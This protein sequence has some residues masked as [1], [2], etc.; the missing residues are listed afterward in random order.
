MKINH[1]F[2]AVIFAAMALMLSACGPDPCIGRGCNGKGNDI[3]N[4]RI[5]LIGDQVWMAENL[6]YDVSGSKCYKNEESNCDKYG[7][8][9]DWATAMA[10]PAS[11]NASSCASQVGVKHRGICPSGWH[12]PSDAE[13][14]TLIDFVGGSSTADISLKA[15][16]GWS[17]WGCNGQDIYGFVALPGGYGYANDTFLSVG[18]EGG[19]WTATFNANYANYIH[20]SCSY[21]GKSKTNKDVLYSVRCLK[22]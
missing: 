18:F 8:L 15:T 5:V 21:V 4:Y 22:D 12:I 11:C 16:S 1:F 14:A 17:G 9:Y 2:L 7:R 3:A 10:L 19:W 20:I 13:W 6:D